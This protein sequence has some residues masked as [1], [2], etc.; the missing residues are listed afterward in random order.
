MQCSVVGVEPDRMLERA[1]WRNRR[2]GK[3]RSV[4]TA[5]AFHLPSFLPQSRRQSKARQGK[6]MQTLT[7]GTPSTYPIPHTLCAGGEE[8]GPG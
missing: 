5:R 2:R 6:A 4:Y 7:S 1:D 3:E 8:H